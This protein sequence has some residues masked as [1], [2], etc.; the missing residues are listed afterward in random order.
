MADNVFS[1]SSCE[2]MPVTSAPPFLP[3]PWGAPPQAAEGCL[4]ALQNLA[5]SR[6]K[7]YLKLK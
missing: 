7:H 5:D 6:A 4:S 3:P 1:E 2:L